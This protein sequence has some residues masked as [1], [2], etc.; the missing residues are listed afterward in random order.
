[1]AATTAIL[2]YE[3]TNRPYANMLRDAID[4]FAG[5]FDTAA[6]DKR[7]LSLAGTQKCASIARAFQNKTADLVSSPSTSDLERAFSRIAEVFINDKAPL[8]EKY[9]IGFQMLKKSNDDTKAVG[10][11]AYRVGDELVYIPV[12]CF[13]GEIQGHELMY[14]VSRDQFVPSDEKWVNY[15]LSR[16]PIEPGVVEKRDRSEITSR[17]SYR[18]SYMS[19]GLK[20]SSLGL[21]PLPEEITL[22]ALATLLSKIF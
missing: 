9:L 4:G 22:N 5:S 17:V 21:P 3:F 12:F 13:N 10:I 20:L 15:L 2:G 7:R 18:P 1:M 11:F 14:L 6:R 16:K 19:S 8:L